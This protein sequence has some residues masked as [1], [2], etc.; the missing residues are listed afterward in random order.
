MA[1]PKPSDWKRHDEIINAG[2]KG[3]N[4]LDALPKIIPEEYPWLK[5][6]KMGF[7]DGE[8]PL[9][10]TLGWQHLKTEHFDTDSFNQAIALR[11]GLTDDGGLIKY[12]N[13]YIMIIPK[14]LREKQMAARHR[15]SER[16]YSAQA[17]GQKY[18]IEDDPRAAE[19][20]NNENVKSE[21]ESTV[22]NTGSEPPKRGRPPKLP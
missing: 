10:T 14:D 12:M 7:C 1:H 17:E 11:F 9:W 19:F 13:N 4:H 8:I 2:S 18:V 5:D 16:L 3:F 15:E 6:F 22:I 21:Y 20:I